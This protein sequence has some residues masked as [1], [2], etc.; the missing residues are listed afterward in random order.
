MLPVLFGIGIET[1]TLEI[2]TVVGGV[3]LTATFAT[4]KRRAKRGATR[5][6]RGKRASTARP[7]RH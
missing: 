1:L 5:P 3:A 4:K 7:R 6:A 2:V